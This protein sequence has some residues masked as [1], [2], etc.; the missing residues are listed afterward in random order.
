[1]HT[2]AERLEFAPPATPGVV[3][4]FL[5]AVLAHGLLVAALTWG[6]H[7]QRD[8]PII[9]AEAELWAAVPVA[10]AP[11]L[12]EPTPEPPE[13]PEPVKPQLVARPAPLPPPVAELPKVDIA[14]EQEKRRLQK[15]K[16]LELEKQQEIKQEKLK[17]DK[18][19]QARLQQEKLKQEQLKADQ[20][21]QEQAEKARLAQAKKQAE[22]QAKQLEAQRE[23][24]LQRIAGL[25]GASGAP[26]AT[27]SA[28]KSAGPSASYA[29]RII[30]RVKPNIVFIEDIAG[31]PTAEV[32]V[33]AAPDGKILASK[34]T[35]SSGVKA[36]DE[37]VLRAIDK[38]E[39]LPR[40]TDGRVPSPLVISFRP[41]D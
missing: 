39:V 12:Q 29:G 18:L 17:Q 41:K 4:A 27:G 6:V 9:S 19:K 40:D 34:L 37:A 11:R 30:A 36:W 20:L 23:K 24:N 32:E 22:Q 14:L 5:L 13:P 31:N 10:A 1:M 7:W 35:K 2:A 21:K 26:N 33:H 25:A 16:Q 15:Q 8:A 38:T 28:L 3:R